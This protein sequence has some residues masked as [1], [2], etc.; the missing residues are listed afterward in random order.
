[1][2]AEHLRAADPGNRKRTD[3]LVE[4]GEELLRVQVKAKQSREWPG[5]KGIHGNGILLIFVDYQHKTLMDR[6]DFYVLN[7]EDW[8]TAVRTEI[9]APGFVERGEVVLDDHFV[10]RW[11]NGFLGWSLQASN[12]AP[13]KEAWDR[14][15]K[16]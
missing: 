12:L 2:Q 7:V 3:I 8:R 13:F 1:M 4:A 10:P 5:I 16:A 9:I 14:F 6:P 11:K 15:P